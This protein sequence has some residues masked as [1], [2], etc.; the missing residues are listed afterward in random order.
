PFFAVAGMWLLARMAEHLG[1]AGR[2]A[3]GVVVALQLIIGLGASTQLLGQMKTSLTAAA[4]ARILAEKEIPAGSVVILDRQLAESFDASGRWKLVE[5][6]FV[7]GGG[8]GPM[9]GLGGPGR[10][11]GGFRPLPAGGQ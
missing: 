8:F 10:P 6:S 7:A 1:T 5:E 11:G 3:V 4:R 9:G 2:V